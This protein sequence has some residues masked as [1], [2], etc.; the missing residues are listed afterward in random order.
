MIPFLRQCVR[1]VTACVLV[2]IFAVPPTIMAQVHV[3]SPAE[4]HQQ[5][6][7]ASRARQQ[8]L[9]ALTAFLSSPQG[10]KALQRVG[11]SAQQV[12]S[13]VSLLSDQELEQLAARAQKAQADFAAGRMTDHDLLIILIAIVALVLIIVAVR[14]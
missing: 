4:L 13:A 3:I 10:E 11:A 12:K 5:T 7:A 8:N 9:D 14:H 6:I 2:T 1:A